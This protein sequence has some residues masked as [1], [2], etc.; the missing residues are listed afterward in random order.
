MTQLHYINKPDEW[1]CPLGHKP[2]M[3][4]NCAHC[5]NWLKSQ[6]SN[7]DESILKVTAEVYLE[8]MSNLYIIE[9]FDIGDDQSINTKAR[10]LAKK[11]VKAY[12][13]DEMFPFDIRVFDYRAEKD[14]D[15]VF[16]SRVNIHMETL[17][18]IGYGE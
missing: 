12:Y 9:I 11:L 2:E 5:S 10:S 4:D 14:W 15:L 8:G 16:L 18:E 3:P 13:K 7:L 6:V 17:K 1:S